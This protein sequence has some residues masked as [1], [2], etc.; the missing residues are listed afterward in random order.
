MMNV[1][2]RTQTKT[3]VC[4]CT[5][6][7]A[8]ESA[9]GKRITGNSQGRVQ[10]QTNATKISVMTICHYAGPMKRIR[11]LLSSSKHCHEATTS[12]EV[13]SQQ[14]AQIAAV[15]E[16]SCKKSSNKQERCNTLPFY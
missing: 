8:D 16:Q 13:Q 11:Y 4:K 3:D 1:R 5:R 10:T 2:E 15:Y 7:N 6:V 12:C 9:E 14:H